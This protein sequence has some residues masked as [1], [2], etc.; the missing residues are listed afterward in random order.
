MASTIRVAAES[1]S[2]GIRLPVAAIAKVEAM[3]PEQFPEGEAR[4][5]LPNGIGPSHLASLAVEVTP[6]T[7]H[8]TSPSTYDIVTYCIDI[9]DYLALNADTVSR[10]MS[11]LRGLISTCSPQVPR[12]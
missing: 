8:V 11:R 6:F 10:V 3:P 9:A 1:A 7:M 4:R 12:L 5:N 2:T